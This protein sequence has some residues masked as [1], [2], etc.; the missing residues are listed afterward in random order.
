[1]SNRLL[2]TEEDKNRIKSMYGLKEQDDKKMSFLNALLKRAMELSKN[3]DSKEPETNTT[4]DTSDVDITDT[5]EIDLSNSGF[6][7]TQ[8]ENIKLL[9]DAMKEKGITN[10]YT[11]IGILSVIAKESGFKPKNEVDYSTTP[12]SRIRSIFGKRVSKYSDQE[13]DSLKRDPKKF[14][15]VVYGGRFGNA[16]DEGYKYRGR[17]FNQLTFKGN[18]KKYGD[19]I[20]VDLVGNPDSANDPKIAAKIALAFFTKGKPSST[21]PEFTNKEDAATYFAD[22]NAGG[23]GASSHRDKAIAAT[24]KFDIKNLA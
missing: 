1:M 8:K 17:G 19:M 6:D 14:F 11:Q 18:Y 3:P 24:E 5:G 10:P 4:S 20:G 12:N 16:P 23:S 7:G 21:F 15:D 2:I 13:L 22:I 9:I